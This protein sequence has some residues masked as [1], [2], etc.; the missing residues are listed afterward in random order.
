MPSFRA[1]LRALQLTNQSRMNTTITIIITTMTAITTKVSNDCHFYDSLAK[2]PIFSRFQGSRVTDKDINERARQSTYPM[3]SMADVLKIVLANSDIE[4]TETVN[5]FD[6]LNRVCAQDV[7][8]KEPLPPFA[9]SI[10]DGFAIKLTDDQ[11]DHI[12]NGAKRVPFVFEVIGSANA[13]DQ[14][15]NISLKGGECVK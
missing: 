10:K 11:R 13:G 3:L 12:V 6:A 9:A 15:I 7:L 1:E 4:E 2:W 8:A 14:V 5:Y